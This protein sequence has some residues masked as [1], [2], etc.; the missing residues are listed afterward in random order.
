MDSSLWWNFIFAAGGLLLGGLLAFLYASRRLRAQQFESDRKLKSIISN[1]EKQKNT[2]DNILRGLEVG[3]LAYGERGKLVTGNLAARRM[4]A[5][6]RLPE[7]FSMFLRRYGQDNG[8][9]A[10]VALQT[11]HIAEQLVLRDRCIRLRLTQTSSL[12][13]NSETS[14][15]IVLQ[16]I[17]EQEREEKQRKEFVANV[18]HELKTPLTTISAYSETLLDWGLKGKA[19]EEIRAD[20]RRIHED[21]ERMDSLVKNLLLLSS[22]DSRGVRAQMHQYDLVSVMRNV[23][24]RMQL[25]ADE[26]GLILESA[27][28]S[29]IP[30]VFGDPGALD[31]ILTNLISNGIKYTDPTGYVNVS[32]QLTNDYISLKIVDNGMGVSKENIG[33][34]FDRFFR[35]DATGSRKYGGTGLGLSIARE[36]TELQGGTISVASALG[37]GTEFVVTIPKAEKTYTETITSL[38]DGAPRREMLYK[39]AERYLLS[40][41]D[42]L[43][44][45]AQEL[46]QM[47]REQESEL[48]RYLLAPL[49]ED[50]L[51][52]SVV[53]A[54]DMLP[55]RFAAEK[56]SANRT[57][58]SNSTRNRRIAAGDNPIARDHQRIRSQSKNRRDS[59]N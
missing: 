9:Q 5:T 54:A 49:A 19:A 38:C 41:L 35:V 6:D 36:L 48:F 39:N 52:Y 50:E 20:V 16:D 40:A 55:A 21:A 13:P 59:P 4:L 46:P 32:V 15:I 29:I 45:P 8:I 58:P 34:L 3:I 57:Q 14:W 30:P 27:V 11:P 18:S 28:L 33:R 7:S 22:I 1:F 24:G 31:Q 23:V 42:D 53:S 47:S 17:T 12:A 37:K 51:D 43:N 2:S 25:Q 44:M 26:K 56:R 10:S